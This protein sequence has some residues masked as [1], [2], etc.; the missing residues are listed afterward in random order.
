M[1]IVTHRENVSTC[2]VNRKRKKSSQYVGVS[3]KK[4]ANKYVSR[5]Y[6]KGVYFHLGYFDTELEA[7]NAYQCKLKEILKETN[8]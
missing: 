3:F 4:W 6:H 8:H 7:S 2:N 5:I 1:Q